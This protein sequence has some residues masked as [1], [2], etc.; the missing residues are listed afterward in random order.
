MNSNAASGQVSRSAPG[1]VDAEHGGRDGLNDNLSELRKDL[2]SLKDNVSR[3]VS[4]AGAEAAK[5]IRGASQSVT[6]QV[7]GAAGSVMDTSSDL[8]SS[9]KEHAQTFAAELERVARRN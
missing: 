3:L 1:H 5:A 7:G 9:A 8:A 4:Q 6:S 2:A